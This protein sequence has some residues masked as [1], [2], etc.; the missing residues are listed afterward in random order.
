MKRLSTLLLLLLLTGRML[1]AQVAVSDSGCMPDPSAAFEVHSSTRGFLGPRI[2]LTS[3]TSAT[4]VVNPVSGLMVYNTTENGDLHRGYYF[5]NKNII[6][7]RWIQ[8][9]LPTGTFQGEMLCW[10]G[11]QWV[12]IAPGTP[13]DVLTFT[14]GVPV[15]AH[16]A[17]EPSILTDSV[18][19]VTSSKALGGGNVSDN[20]AIVTERGLC[21]GTSPNPTV[22]DDTSK[23]GAGSGTFGKDMDGLA[24]NTTYYVRA[25]ATNEV[26][27]G[28]GNEKSFTTPS[29]VNS[30]ITSTVTAI[31][32]GTAVSGGTITDGGGA[33]VTARGVCWDTAAGPTTADAHS[34]DGSGTGSFSS[35]LTGLIANTTYHVRAYATSTIGTYYGNDVSFT[36]SSTAVPATLV[37][38]APTG[39]TA[40]TATAGGN[41]LS[42]GGAAVIFRGICWN[43][44]ASPT[45]ANSH[46]TDGSGIGSYSCSLTGLASNTLY[47]FRA[48]VVTT[49]GTFYGN[50]LT[51]ITSLSLTTT[52]ATSITQTTA[53]SGG[54][55]VAG[56]GQAVTARGVCWDTAANPTL[57]DPHSSNGTGTGTFVSNLTGL[58]GGTLYYVRA[59]GTNSSGTFYGNQQTFTT[60]PASATVV[61]TEAYNI[62]TTS[63]TSGGN[64]ISSGGYPVT[65]RGVCW[66]PSGTPTILDDSTVNGSGTGVFSSQITGLDPNHIFI[67]RA[68]A[69]SAAGTSYGNTVTFR[70]LGDLTLPS[71]T[72]AVISNISPPTAT[73]GGNVTLQ[74][75]STVLFRGVCWSTSPN[76]TLADSHTA[77]GSGTGSFVSSIT[78]LASG[79]NYYVRAYAMNS[80]GTAYGN[81][82]S[83]NNPYYIG[84]S[85][86]GGIIFYLDGTGHHGLISAISNQSPT[87]ERWGCENTSIPGTSTSIG[88]GQANTT[89]IVNG[90]ATAGIAAHICDTLTLNG[91]TDWFLPSKDELYQMY[92]QRTTIGGFYNDIYWSST[93]NDAGTAWG[94]SFYTG[95]QSADHKHDGNR[96]RAIRSF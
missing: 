94:H 39:I 61:T 66:R 50:E 17:Q 65:A 72:T 35:A 53:T 67:V 78:G 74:G 63:A 7:N 3:V 36:T 37:T 86:G 88:T 68:Y 73:C 64:V 51:L 2:A 8:V 58:T 80:A 33:S 52:A 5:W 76:P 34:T 96:V 56:G 59:Y 31:T 27:T 83:I 14:G 20:G 6:P 9:N 71:V 10:N 79:T 82:V 4:P 21:F 49:L 89:L 57:A 32:P 26:G 87:G 25:Y 69:I 15:W 43:T 77:D 75:G 91:Y 60:S 28:Y 62:L 84:A 92:Q 85:F 93:E 41:I 38:T 11:V 22:S 81:E 18:T 70:T 1:H 90:C 48:Y 47:Y 30:I 45:L 95:S 16:A 29:G 54:T 55:I 40:S 46:T 13:G 42:G 19:S 44:M 24:P 23:A 12:K